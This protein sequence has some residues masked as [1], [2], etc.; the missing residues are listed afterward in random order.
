MTIDNPEHAAPTAG[1]EPFPWLL[2]Y[3]R[4]IYSHKVDTTPAGVTLVRLAPEDVR[5]EA[6]HLAYSYDGRHW[7]PLNDNRPTL[8]ASTL[9]ERI[10]DPFLRRGP[11]GWFHLLATCGW[12]SKDIYYRRSR[13]LIHWEQPRY[14]PITDGLPQARNAWAPEWVWDH[15]QGNY[16]VF[17]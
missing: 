17:W 13:D 12:S 15:E 16:F 6:L 5:I 14:L 11:D 3:F 7:T 2:A 9:E 1:G 8:P 4:Q 10:R